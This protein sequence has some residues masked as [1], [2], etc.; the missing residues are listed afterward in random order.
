MRTIIG[1]MLISLALSFASATAA[2]GACSYPYSVGYSVTTIAG[3]RVALWYPTLATPA[4]Y[5]YSNRFSDVGETPWL[6]ERR[7]RAE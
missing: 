5:T 4:S 3:L 6:Q 7:L 2:Q 1:G